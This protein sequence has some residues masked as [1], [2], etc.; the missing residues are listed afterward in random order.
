MLQG[1]IPSCQLFFFF[2]AFL[3]PHTRPGSAHCGGP[4]TDSRGS[5]RGSLEELPLS[6]TAGAA[7]QKMLLDYSVYMAKY[8]QHQSP[9][10]SP[11]ASESPGRS[12]D[13]SPKATKKVWRGFLA[14]NHFSY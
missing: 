13:S 2:L 12:P 1:Q 11:A 8:V 6:R 7:K 10:R 4:E 9:I 14:V 5:S 3:P